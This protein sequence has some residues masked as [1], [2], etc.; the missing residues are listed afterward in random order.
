MAVFGGTSRGYGYPVT[1]V[2]PAK[3]PFA[4]RHTSPPVSAQSETPI[5]TVEE[6]LYRRQR[7]RDCSGDEGAVQQAAEVQQS[8]EPTEN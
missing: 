8:V 5:G 7:R 3:Q 2:G 4:Y 6:V 1:F